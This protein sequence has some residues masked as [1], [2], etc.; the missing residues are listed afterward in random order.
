[1][2]IFV[3]V[4]EKSITR[5]SLYCVWELA[6]KGER[7]LLVARWIDPDA[8]LSGADDDT[9]SNSEKEARRRSPGSSLR[10]A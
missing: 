3:D 9:H 2:R 10:A 4:P 8:A 5:R 7:A 6:R 1:M